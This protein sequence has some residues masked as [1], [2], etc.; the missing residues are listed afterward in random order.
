MKGG[1]GLTWIRSFRKYEENFYLYG[2]SKVLFAVVGDFYNVD[3]AKGEF[4]SDAKAS[5]EGLPMK[6]GSN[7]PFMLLEY[8]MAILKTTENTKESL[9]FIMYYC[10]LEEYLGVSS[11]ESDYGKKYGTGASFFVYE[12]ALNRQIF[13]TEQPFLTLRGNLSSGNAS[14]R[15]RE[16]YYT[17]EQKANLRRLID[18]A[19]PI[20][21]AQ[22]VIFDMLM[23]EMEGYFRGGQSL[24][25][26]CE[27]LQNRAELYLKEQK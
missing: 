16:Y 23:E 13:E 2:C 14:E 19:V 17:E 18:S 10:T 12:E 7:K 25:A 15:F 22:K 1:P 26:A 6:D 11:S 24:D 4:L 21:K 5:L 9:D 8:P 3:Q 27:I 20:T